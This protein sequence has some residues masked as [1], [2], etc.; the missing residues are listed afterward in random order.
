MRSVRGAGLGGET[1]VCCAIAV[2][3]LIG[4][5]A[6]VLFWWLVD[7]AQWSRV[8]SGSPLLPALGFLFLPWT[9]LMYVLFWAVGGLSVLGWFFVVVA[10]L[11]DIG[12]Y[13]GGGYRNRDRMSS[14][15]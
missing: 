7:P 9:T 3:G 6:L 8:F 12:T 1:P 10:F 4:P 2:L 13:G 11:A 14:Y 15:R 5:R